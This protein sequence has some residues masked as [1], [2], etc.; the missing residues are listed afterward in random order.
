M[1]GKEIEEGYVR[2]ADD[3][4]REKVEKWLRGVGVYRSGDGKF[5]RAKKAKL[6]TIGLMAQNKK[7]SISPKTRKP[8]QLVWERIGKIISPK[9]RRPDQLV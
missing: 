6:N 5:Y 9:T 1:E 8:G 7:K 2:R 4:K 3:Q